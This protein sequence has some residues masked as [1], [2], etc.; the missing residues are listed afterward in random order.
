MPDYGHDLLF[1]V[2]VTP[3]A[4]DSRSVLDLAQAADRG[5]LDLVAIQDHPYQPSHLDTWTLISYLAARTEHVHFTPDVADLALR[6]PALLAKAAASLDV[7][8]GG[9][10]TLGVGGGAMN[11]A[12]TSI[13]GP[14]RT[15]GQIVEY[16][17]ESLTVLRRALAGQKVALDG[18]H[19]HIRGYQAGPL[20]AHSVPIWLGAFKPRMLNLTGRLAD[21]W[22]C[23]LNIYVPPEDVP[24]AQQHIDATAVEAGRHA[25]DIRRIYNVLGTITTGPSAAGQGLTGDAETWARTL[26]DW[27]LTLGFDTFI[28]WAADDPALQLDLFIHDVVPRVRE[29][30]TDARTAS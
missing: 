6:P 21:G 5:G 27:V 13:G 4:A 10:V 22:I 28:F 26:T 12:I 18:K 15:P 23:P 19:H 3:D 24:A 20:P 30:V 9:R 25:A 14:D 29:L 17:A 11:Q 16:T 8:T 1:G 7:L 2:S